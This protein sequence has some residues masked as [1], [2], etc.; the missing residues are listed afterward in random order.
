MSFRPDGGGGG[1]VSSSRQIATSG[2]LSGGGDLSAD[3]TL[4]LTNDSGSPGNSRYYGTDAG[5]TKGYHALPAGSSGAS[6]DDILA[7][8]DVL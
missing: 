3:R 7:T 8:M 2:S 5:G 4:A 6:V 1:G